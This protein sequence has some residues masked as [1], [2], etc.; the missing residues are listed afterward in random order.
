MFYDANATRIAEAS[1]SL[2]LIAD[3]I[4]RTCNDDELKILE[5]VSKK[6]ANRSWKAIMILMAL[7]IVLITLVVLVLNYGIV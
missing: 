2:K 4:G 6:K 1:E 3:T 5:A 7:T